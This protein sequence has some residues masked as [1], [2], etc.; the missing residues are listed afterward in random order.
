MSYLF[1]AKV[2]NIKTIFIVNLADK[3]EKDYSAEKWHKSCELETT[4]FGI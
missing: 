4:R 1:V 2:I 3:S